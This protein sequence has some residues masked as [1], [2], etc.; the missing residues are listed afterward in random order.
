ME[1]LRRDKER[2]MLFESGQWYDRG[3]LYECTPGEIQ[4]IEE[5]HLV[6]CRV[7]EAVRDKFSLYWT[8]TGSEAVASCAVPAH[9]LRRQKIRDRVELEKR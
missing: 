9:L 5:T 6:N 7:T 3:P 2:E 4:Y 1:Q 8:N